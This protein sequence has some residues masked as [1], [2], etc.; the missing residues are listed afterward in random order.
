MVHHLPKWGRVAM[1]GCLLVYRQSRE[2]KKCPRDLK[3]TDALRMFERFNE[4]AIKAVMMAQE[5]PL[6]FA[7]IGTS[8]LLNYNTFNYLP[9]IGVT[10]HHGAKSCATSS[11]V[12]WSNR[13]LF[14]HFVALPC[15]PASLTSAQYKLNKR[16]SSR[17]LDVLATTMWVPRCCWWE[18]WW[19]TPMVPREKCSRSS[20]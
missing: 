4:K 15:K 20:T 17:S 14:L 2:M 13:F 5:E 7:F 16:S 1:S 8:N 6:C 3:P 12:G 10:K 11:N 18:W 19:Q 9:H